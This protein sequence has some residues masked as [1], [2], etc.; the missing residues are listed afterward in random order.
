MNLRA[1][2]AIYAFEMA[3]TGRTLVQSIVAPVIT[4]A[5]YFVVFGAAMGTRISQIEGVQYGAFI[6]PG[7]I[8][9]T[10]LTQS[11]TNAAFGIYFWHGLPGYEQ[12]GFIG[13]V[14]GAGYA[15]FRVWRGRHSYRY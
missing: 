9:L 12:L 1:I 5:L 6:V 2:W 14:A 15:M 3:R 13:V 11:V 7:L 8:M 4:T 10:L